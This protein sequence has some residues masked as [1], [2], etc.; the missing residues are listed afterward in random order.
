MA[1][2][3]S[4]KKRKGAGTDGSSTQKKR[5]LLIYVPA[6]CSV[7]GTLMLLSVIL[8]AAPLTIPQYMGYEIY[9]VVSGSMEPAILIGRSGWCLVLS[10]WC[11]V[12]SAW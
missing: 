1:K 8:A 2:K 11:L 3:R 9:N 5:G 4:R 12:L 6:L 10:A 7:I